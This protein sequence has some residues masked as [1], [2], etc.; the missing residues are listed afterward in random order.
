MSEIA[1]VGVSPGRT[2]GEV[3]RMPDPVGEPTPGVTLP[4]GA[5]RAAEAARIEAAASQV[6]ADPGGTRG[7]SQR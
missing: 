7:A 4:D 1:G 5:D 2:V 6:R 3:V